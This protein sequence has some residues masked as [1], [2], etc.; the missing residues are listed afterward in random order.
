MVREKNKS[1]T[2]SLTFPFA[3]KLSKAGNKE[4]KS[5]HAL[6]RIWNKVDMLNMDSRRF[7]KC[8]MTQFLASLTSRTCGRQ[9]A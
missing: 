4:E 7:P 3:I 9:L 6:G 2:P 1:T 5:R 8:S